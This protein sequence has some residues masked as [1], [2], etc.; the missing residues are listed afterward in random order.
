M[1]NAKVTQIKKIPAVFNAE[2]AG[3][4]VVVIDVIDTTEPNP[5][6]PTDERWFEP[7]TIN[8]RDIEVRSVELQLFYKVGLDITATLRQN[9]IAYRL[10]TE[11][12]ASWAADKSTADLQELGETDSKVE[13]ALA[14]VKAK[15][16]GK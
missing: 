16:V 15:T 4:L 12:L 5:A 7:P 3:M 8:R 6:Q 11:R 10:L 1:N 14:F 13:E 2:E 9:P